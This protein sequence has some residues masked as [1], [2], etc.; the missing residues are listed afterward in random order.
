MRR[1]PLAALVPLGAVPLGA[2]APGTQ[3]ASATAGPDAADLRLA[4][5]PGSDLPDLEG[6]WTI[7]TFDKRSDPVDGTLVIEQHGAALQYQWHAPGEWFAE[8]YG[9][10][11]PAGDVKLTGWATDG[12]DDARVRF[13]GVADDDGIAGVIDI[14]TERASYKEMFA[15]IY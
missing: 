12:D 11:T 10:V 7:T 2:C 5:A 8:L 14:T 6:E 4:K 9:A 15:E 13:E 3:G 1:L